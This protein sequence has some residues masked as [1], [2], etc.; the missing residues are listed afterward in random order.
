[1][2]RTFFYCS[3][4]I[5]LCSRVLLVELLKI[6]PRVRFHTRWHRGVVFWPGISIMEALELYCRAD[7]VPTRVDHRHD[8]ALRNLVGSTTVCKVLSQYVKK[9]LRRGH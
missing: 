4:A 9:G 1:M 6:T 7:E 3:I 8:H 2:I 5:E